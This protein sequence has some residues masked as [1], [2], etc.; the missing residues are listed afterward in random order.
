M[1]SAWNSRDLSPTPNEHLRLQ[2]IQSDHVHVLS[3]DKPINKYLTNKQMPSSY[4]RYLQEEGCFHPFRIT[5]LSFGVTLHGGNL[6][7]PISV[8]KDAYV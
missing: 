7:Y 2:H 6:I 1:S 8:T 5:A 3:T 4:R